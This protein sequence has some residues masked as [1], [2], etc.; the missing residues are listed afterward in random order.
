MCEDCLTD[1]LPRLGR[2]AAARVN[3]QCLNAF[4]HGTKHRVLASERV[5]QDDSL[6][7]VLVVLSLPLRVK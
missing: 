7:K 4:V 5:S 3:L 2:S 1:P 6:S